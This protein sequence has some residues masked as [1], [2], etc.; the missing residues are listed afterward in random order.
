[1]RHPAS[2]RD[3]AV[4]LSKI[5]ITS[6]SRPIFAIQVTANT[7]IRSLRFSF[8]LESLVRLT[9]LNS[10]TD[11]GSRRRAQAQRADKLW[12]QNRLL[13]IGARGNHSHPRSSFLFDERQVFAGD[14]R[15]CFDRPNGRGMAGPARHVAVDAFDLFIAAC[16]SR[17]FVCFLA[18][19]LIPYANRN[20]RQVVEHIQLSNHQ[21]GDA[22]NHASVAEQRQIKPARAAGTS[23]DGAEFVAA[24]A[25]VFSLRPTLQTEKFGRER[26]AANA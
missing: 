19:H 5:A 7:T 24:L 10:L 6:D 15:Q 4:S 17:Y 22:V 2:L 18:V 23:G 1:M 12:H 26:T 11:S 16:L 25:Q 20:L 9:R 8:Q 14:F 13:T 3:S 21:P